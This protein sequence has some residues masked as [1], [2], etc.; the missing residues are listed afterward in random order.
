MR[1]LL[2]PLVV[3]TALLPLACDGGSST[4]VTPPISTSPVFLG[5]PTLIPNDNP[6]VPMAMRLAVEADREVQVFVRIL[7]GIH[8]DSHQ[9]TA[10]FAE[11]HVGLAVVGFRPNRSHDVMVMIRDQDGR[12]TVHPTVFNFASPPL[13]ALFPPITV[14]QSQ[15]AAMEPG[16]TLLGAMSF[17]PPFPSF[18]IMLDASGEVVWYLD[19]TQD[20]NFNG[21]TLF[22]EL[23]PQGSVV[24][25]IGRFGL[26]EVDMLGNASFAFVTDLLSGFS[27][28]GATTLDTDT[29]HH[30]FLDL[31]ISTGAEMSFLGSEQRML[32]NYPIDEVD[33]SMTEPLAETVGDVILEM[34]RNGTIVNRIR[35]TDILDPYRMTYD[36]LNGFWNPPYNSTRTRDWA[37]GNSL[38][39]DHRDDAYIV[40]L[41]HQDAIVKIQRV[42]NEVVW[43]LGD[44]R[45]WTGNLATKL[46]NPVGDNFSYPFHQHHANLSSRGT[47]MVYDNGNNRAIPPEAPMARNDQYSRG[48]EYEIDATA[49]TVRQVW[50]YGEPASTPQTFFSAFLSSCQDLPLTGNVL[51][52]DGGHLSMT[53]SNDASVFEVT[54]G[55]NPQMVFKMQLGDPM[56]SRNWN[57]FRAER[58]PLYRF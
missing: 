44:P 46:L 10:N 35:L 58:G 18:V 41:R 47:L 51:I 6:L 42:T 3:L 53:L 33:P 19:G 31:P 27:V 13:P 30:D 26:T 24:I 4:S 14:T 29:V 38:E 36:S 21:F 54:R 1:T 49:M 23:R 50:Q 28:P 25:N 32:P 20:I 57:V 48:V 15:S 7:D 2:T 11:R 22:G 17:T 12:E 43:I 16:I 8:D 45:R 5:T 9:V 37:H 52:G 56:G 40:S 34:R 39:Y 55:T